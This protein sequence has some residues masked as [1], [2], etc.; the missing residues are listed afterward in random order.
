MV[1]LIFLPHC[2]RSVECKSKLGRY[3]YELIGCGR[4]RICEF[5]KKAESL[6]YKVFIVPGASI[7]KKILK[8]FPKPDMAIGVACDA[9]LKEGIALM[10]KEGINSKSLM[11]LKDG[12]VNTEV[13]FDKLYKML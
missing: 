9:E 12:C 8:E 4:C 6:G 7:I 10:K 2:L 3:G 1:K 11:L 5:K 13:D